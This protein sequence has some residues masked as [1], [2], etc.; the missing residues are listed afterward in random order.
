MRRTSPPAG[1]AARIF[2]LWF[3]LF[4]VPSPLLAQPPALQP[5]PTVVF[6][7]DLGVVDDSVGL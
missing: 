5:P 6:M 2:C 1:K 3:A 7:T 4:L